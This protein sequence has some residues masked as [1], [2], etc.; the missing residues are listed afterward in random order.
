MALKDPT[1]QKIIDRDVAEGQDND[2]SGTPIIYVNGNELKDRS[3]T[4]FSQMIESELK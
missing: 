1:I 3:L 4:G 2:V